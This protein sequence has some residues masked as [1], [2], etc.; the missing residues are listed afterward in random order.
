M[1][2]SK[3]VLK[4]KCSSVCGNCGF[5]AKGKSEED[6]LA[7]CAVHE[8]KNHNMKPEKIARIKRQNQKIFINPYFRGGCKPTS[9]FNPQNES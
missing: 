2:H 9:C 5:V 4:F 6:I 3:F 8:T 1:W 7:Q